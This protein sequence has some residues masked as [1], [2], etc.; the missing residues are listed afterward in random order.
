[1]VGTGKLEVWLGAPGDPQ[2]TDLSLFNARGQIIEVLLFEG[3][4]TT[5]ALEHLFIEGTTIRANTAQVPEGAPPER[6][7]A[8]S[9]IVWDIPAHGGYLVTPPACPADGQWRIRGE[10][11]FAD[12]SSAT[13]ANAQQCASGSVADERSAGGLKVEIIPRAIVRGKRKRI[14][15]R[16]AST[17]KAC[18]AGATVRIGGWRAVTDAAGRATLTI[19]VRKRRRVAVT[20]ASQRC[21]NARATL[22]T[23]AR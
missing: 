2:K 7:F 23:R 12:G 11:K 14:H 22:L 5:A 15:V 16:V 21:G 20:V 10:F 3:T 8:A 1:L 9:H 19:R 17:D 4:N 13:A 6:R 18:I